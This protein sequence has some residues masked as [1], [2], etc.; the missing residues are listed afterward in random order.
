M[1]GRCCV[2]SY[3]NESFGSKEIAILL[4]LG[5]Y[6]SFIPQPDNLANLLEEAILSVY[7]KCTVS[8]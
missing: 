4:E 6:Y 3:A 2:G 7:F 1:E 5:T 8:G